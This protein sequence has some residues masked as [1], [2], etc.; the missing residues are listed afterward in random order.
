ML[1]PCFLLLFLFILTPKGGKPPLGI[2]WSFTTWRTE[3]L[4]H[5]RL[6]GIKCAIFENLL[7]TTK[8]ESTPLWVL[9]S[10]VIKSIEISIHGDEGTGSGKYNPEFW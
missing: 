10:P 8:I 2:P 3:C 9:G 5:L 7:T 6:H 4:L 1:I